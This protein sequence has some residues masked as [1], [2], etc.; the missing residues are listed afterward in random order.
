MRIY[1]DNAATSWPKPESVYQAVDRFQRDLGGSAGRGGHQAAVGTQRVVDDARRAI[2]S[3][4]GAH[5][6]NSIALMFNGTDALNAA[7]HGVLRPGDHVV[8]TVCDHNSVL[9]PLRHA[10]KA[11]GCEI[12]L[13]DC[14]DHAIVDPNELL[15][16]VRQET[17]LVAMTHASNVTGA[18]QPVPQVS[19]ALSSTDTLLLVDAAQS[20]GHVPI[21]VAGWD[22]PLLAAPGHKGLMGPTGTGFLYVK[23]GIEQQVLPWRQGGT[24]NLSEVQYQPEE[25]PTR[26]ECGNSNA[27]CL[28]GLVAGIEYLHQQGLDKLREHE[29][30]LTE[31]LLQGLRSIEGCRI[32]GPPA[33]NQ[34]VGVVSVTFD[35][36]D[37]HEAATVLEM[38]AGVQCRA[39]LHCAPEMHQRMGTMETGALRFSTGCF[40]TS[41]EIDQAIAA[42]QALA[43]QPSGAST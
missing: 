16:A 31:R 13:V 8:T 27:I 34:R 14:D 18:L 41:E 43:A 36:Y 7:I 12:T 33:A 11:L 37:P 29:I 32:V 30:L 10:E 5:Q 24:G 35:A 39:G 20:V 38:A 25:M 19:Q 17:R 4:I 6:P 26:L 42:A 23:P 9:R 22:V 2:A 1:L 40:T 21:D 28:A 15:A 3:V